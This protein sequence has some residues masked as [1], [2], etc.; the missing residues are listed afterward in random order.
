MNLSGLD[1]LSANKLLADDIPLGLMADEE[2]EEDLDGDD[3]TADEPY[4]LDGSRRER[5]TIVDAH[6][7]HDPMSV[8]EHH[9]VVA[10]ARHVFLHRE[11]GVVFVREAASREDLAAYELTPLLLYGLSVPGTSLRW[12]MLTPVDKPA[13]IVSVLREGWTRANGLRGRPDVLKLSRQLAASAV[14]LPEMLA[15]SDVRLVVADGSDKAF[16]ASLRRCQEDA[17]WAS[18]PRRR[19][20]PSTTLDQLNR[21]ATDR[22]NHSFQTPLSRVNARMEWWRNLP[23]RAADLPPGD[24]IDWRPGVWLHAWEKGVAPAGRRHFHKDALD[25]VVWLLTTPP[26]VDDDELQETIFANQQTDDLPE[27]ARALVRCWPT[28]PSELSRCIG[29][30]ARS[31]EWFLERKAALD[32]QQRNRLCELLGLELD[33]NFQ[34]YETCAPCVLIARTSNAAKEAYEFLSHGGD[35]VFSIEALPATGLPDP[36]W[37]YLVF[38]ACG[39]APNIMLVARGSGVDAKMSR[40]LFINF[41]GAKLIRSPLYRDIVRTCAKS[42]RDSR[43][44]IRAMRELNDRRMSFFADIA[45]EI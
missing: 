20:T 5:M 22:H 13:S 3:V 11:Y 18:L 40:E 14:A 43:S 1:T 24:E 27:V 12:V 37:R 16:S 38:Q 4:D 2:D 39:G 17:M 21:C 35:L 15:A 32:H 44:N 25:G 19:P 28:S 23:P 42:C 8:R 26:I 9:L 6:D 45:S 30:T 34:T 7:E 41:Q 33:P 10:T 29:S 36:S 31:L